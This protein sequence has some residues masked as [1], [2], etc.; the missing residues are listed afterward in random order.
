[1]LEFAP[2][3]NEGLIETAMGCSRSALHICLFLKPLGK[4]A[5]H[6]IVRQI[7]ELPCEICIVVCI[8][9]QLKRRLNVSIIM[10]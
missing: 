7:M 9:Q 2:L 6:Y 10:H 3:H 8:N 4:A 5:N 1:M